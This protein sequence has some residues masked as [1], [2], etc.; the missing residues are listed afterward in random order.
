MRFLDSTLERGILPKPLR[1]ALQFEW[2]S[3]CP[4]IIIKMTPKGLMVD[5]IRPLN[6]S[7]RQ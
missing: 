2:Y 6:E 4:V 5:P 7:N 3:H 1:G